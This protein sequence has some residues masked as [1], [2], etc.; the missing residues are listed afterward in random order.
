MNG[1]RFV[2]QIGIAEQWMLL[3]LLMMP[4]LL[5]I[6]YHL[7]KLAYGDRELAEP[8]DVVVMPPELI[9]MNYTTDL[10]VI[11]EISRAVIQL[12]QVP[13]VT[14]E[15]IKPY[16]ESYEAH[17]VAQMV[18]TFHVYRER[19]IREYLR[20]VYHTMPRAQARPQH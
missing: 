17:K 9:W 11:I 1:G 14:Y 8:T 4:V 18:G 2:Y 20:T 6:G 13:P 5:F 16:L 15:Q 12:R 3:F 10:D 19:D 7:A